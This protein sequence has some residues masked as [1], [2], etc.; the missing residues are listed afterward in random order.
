VGELPLPVQ[1]KL[2]HF[3]EDGGYRPIGSGRAFTSDARVL[4]ATNRDLTAEVR[5]GSFR[6]DLFY[7]LDV[8]RV[9]VPPLRERGRDV[10]LL[11]RH[12]AA[13]YAREESCDPV[14]F[15]PEAEE[16]LVR[17]P[18]PGNV[19]ELRNLIERLTILN[20]GRSIGPADLPPD[21]AAPPPARPEVEGRSIGTE[22]ADAERLLLE[23]ALREA[24]G[25]KG[26]AATSLG[27]SRHALKR[28]L[29][30]LGIR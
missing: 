20:A 3:L 18:W 9:R 8:V 1:A 24:G 28:R 25:H 5:A 23:R 22:L 21:M 14:V 26:R 15:T 30:R 11:A 6:E 12:Y 27:I 4:A 10:V 13:R 17:Y 29:H 19:R 2:L 7:R 16:L